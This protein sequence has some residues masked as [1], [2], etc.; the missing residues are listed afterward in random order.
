MNSNILKPLENI[1]RYL[2]DFRGKRRL[3]RLLFHRKIKTSRDVNVKVPSGI[4]YLLPNL[5]EALAYDIFING[6]YEPAT[7]QF[8]LNR[9]PPSGLLLD[10]GANIGSVSIPL[11]K[12]RRDLTC[13]AVEAAPWIY[14]YLQH[15]V[16]VNGLEAQV[17]LHNRALWV[18]SDQ[19]LPFYSSADK[20]GTGSLSPVFTKES[21]MV[22]TITVDDLIRDQ[23]IGRVDMIKID[24]EGYEYFAFQG[25]RKLL[26]RADAP[27][28]LFEFVDWAQE[29][30][31]VSPGADQE[32]LRSYGYQIYR[33]S[34]EK[35]KWLYTDNLTTGFHMLLA[36]K[37]NLTEL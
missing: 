9:L 32:L 7:H 5:Q 20:F 14:R 31:G 3:G 37:K 2:P 27:E 15:N 19:Q 6:I 29:L 4:Q 34:P 17:Q 11:L 25:A 24:I 12:A 28:I 1:F 10:L 35:R 16:S 8:F 22:P 33:Y 13:I 23:G 30:A 36:S 18:E 26:E 21:V